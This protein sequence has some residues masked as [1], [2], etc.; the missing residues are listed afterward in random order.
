MGLFDFFKK[1]RHDDL[2]DDE[3]FEQ[4]DMW[5]E[6]EPEPEPEP[7]EAPYIPPAAPLWDEPVQKPEGWPVMEPISISEKVM[8]FMQEHTPEEIEIA[9]A[10]AASEGMKAFRAQEFEQARGFFQLGS[11]LGNQKAQAL[12]GSMY[13][14]GYQVPR[15]L[16]VGGAGQPAGGGNAG[17]VCRRIRAGRGGALRVLPREYRNRPPDGALLPEPRGGDGAFPGA[18]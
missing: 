4:N 3:D 9:A 6:A 8:Q 13:I 11:E 12:L 10:N 2:P 7:E 18:I 16:P 15:D 14:Q 1:N 17:T 5:E